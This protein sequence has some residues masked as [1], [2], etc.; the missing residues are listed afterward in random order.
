MDGWMDGWRGLILGGLSVLER[1]HGLGDGPLIVMIWLGRG[2]S[3]VYSF[4]LTICGSLTWEKA[5]DGERGELG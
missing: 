4:Y 3:W 1:T 5:V 2:E